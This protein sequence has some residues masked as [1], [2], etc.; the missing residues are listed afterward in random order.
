M[1]V[2]QAIFLGV[3]QGITE[4]LPVSS[5]GHLVIVSYILDWPNPGLTLGAIL[6]LGTL[7]AI[8][9]Y[10]WEDLWLLVVAAVESLRLGSLA[11]PEARIA[12]G[13]VLGT[14]PGAVFG[15]LFEDFF[16]RLF[17]APRAAAGFLLVTALLLIVA[18]R[19]GSR[20]RPLTALSWLD[21]LLIGFA[22][23]LAIAPGISRSGSTI[24]GAMLLGFRRED[25]ARFSFL[26]AVP[27]TLGSGLYQV[28]G[29]A[30]A[31]ATEA[32]LGATM[33][34]LVAAAVAGYLAIAALLAVIRRRGSLF[35]FAA[36]CTLLSLLVLTGTLG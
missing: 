21:A 20:L 23:T 15:F 1:S 18:E 11:D 6:H 19:V 32:S 13:L 29:L 36:Y 4:F 3:V 7:L 31:G 24:T 22:Q 26:L 10:F 30:T 8:V 14:V 25:A 5:S 12:W 2:W 35:M 9:I 28:L 33:A 27:I 17:G 34:G 16:E